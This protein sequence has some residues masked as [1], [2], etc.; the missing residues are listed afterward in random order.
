MPVAPR[1]GRVSRNSIEYIR[2]IGIIVA[3]RE[4]RVSRNVET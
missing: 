2:E 1:E 4:G 3:P